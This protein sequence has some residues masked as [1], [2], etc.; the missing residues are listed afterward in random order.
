MEEFASVTSEESFND[1]FGSVDL[2]EGVEPIPEGWVECE[3]Y[4]SGDFAKVRRFVSMFE[5]TLD[6]VYR[7]LEEGGRV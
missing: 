7:T 4:I 3:V 6:A 2:Y 1:A 5:D